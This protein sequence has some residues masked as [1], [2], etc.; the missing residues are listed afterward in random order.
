VAQAPP[1]DDGKP[2]KP[3]ASTFVAAGSLAE[4]S[5]ADPRR[6]AANRENMLEQARLAYQQAIATDPNYVPAYQALAHLYLTQG[7]MERAVATYEKVLKAHPKEAAVWYDLGMCYS[8]Q[9]RWDNAVT[10]LAR[11]V[12]LEPENRPYVNTLGFCLARA[13]RYEDSLACFQK[14]GSPAQAHYN[15][16]RMLHHIKQDEIAKQHL[17]LAIQIDPR[18]ASARQ[19]LAQLDSKAPAANGPAVATRTPG[20]DEEESEIDDGPGK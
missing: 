4:K 15:L 17:H 12:E 7:D 10:N 1:E 3:H 5:A 2:H 8:R 13:G 16:A 20:S 11:A 6:D 18:L 19:L 9:K 14:I